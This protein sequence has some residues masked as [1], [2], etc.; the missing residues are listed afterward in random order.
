MSSQGASKSGS[1]RAKGS[2][3]AV[4][5]LKMMRMMS[6]GGPMALAMAV[7]GATALTAKPR[8]RAHTASAHTMAR[9]TRKRSTLG[10]RFTLQYTIAQ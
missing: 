3:A 8:A 7:V 1:H 6:S 4:N 2:L 9:K 5:S 10:F